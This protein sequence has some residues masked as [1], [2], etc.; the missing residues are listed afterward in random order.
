M[1]RFGFF[2]WQ[3]QTCHRLNAPNSPEHQL[4]VECFVIFEWIGGVIAC[5]SVC[6]LIN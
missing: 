2:Y 4:C 3:K 5:E 1:L 6:F